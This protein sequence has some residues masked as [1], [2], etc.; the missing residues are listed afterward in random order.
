MIG[1]EAAILKEAA[2][3]F[4]R[5]LAHELLWRMARHST[6][7]PAEVRRVGIMIIKFSFQ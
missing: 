4:V 7:L 1:S 2:A 3:E 6:E 5:Y